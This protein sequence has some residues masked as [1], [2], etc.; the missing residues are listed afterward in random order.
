M[1]IVMTAMDCTVVMIVPAEA[2]EAAADDPG[3]G[4][5]VAGRAQGARQ[6]RDR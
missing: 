5:R 4:D 3:G 6:K 2:S 1:N